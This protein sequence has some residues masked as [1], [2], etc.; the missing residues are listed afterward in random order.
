MAE[1]EAP[2]VEDQSLADFGRVPTLSEREPGIGDREQS[3]Q[4]GEPGDHGPV[5]LEDTVVDDVLE[6]Q[7]RRDDQTGVED[8]QHEEIGDL[9]AVRVRERGNAPRRPRRQTAPT[10]GRI[11]A[12][13]RV[14]HTPRITHT[15]HTP[16]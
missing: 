2:E 13:E 10:L 4:Q 11:L 5:L 12:R 7:R 14:H 15:T 8:D 1:D 16:R 3:N 9:P 6:Q